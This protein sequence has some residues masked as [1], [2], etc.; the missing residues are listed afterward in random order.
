[1]NHLKYVGRQNKYKPIVDKTRSLLSNNSE[2]SKKAADFL[3]QGA[4][5]YIQ[6]LFKLQKNRKVSSSHIEEILADL[7]RMR[8]VNELNIQ[9]YVTRVFSRLLF[10]Q[11]RIKQP[12][13]EVGCGDGE[14][15]RIA[16][17]EKILVGTDLHFNKNNIIHFSCKQSHAYLVCSDIEKLPFPSKHFKTVLCI[18]TIYHAKN[19]VRALKELSRVT[20]DLLLFDDMSDHL[21]IN[22]PFQ[23]LF[24]QFGLY[25]ASKEMSKAVSKAYKKIIYKKVL[26]DFEI[27]ETPFM[28][29]PLAN[30]SYFLYDLNTIFQIDATQ[31]SQERRESTLEFL[32]SVVAPLIR[33]DREICKAKGSAYKLIIAKRKKST[34]KVSPIPFNE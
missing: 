31:S 30:I 12:S 32:K 1:M 5:F 2:D 16:F 11:K 15:S 7:H 33:K 24:R 14:T 26:K 27:K 10:G 34:E 4:L 6:N 18:N 25:K 22:R 19:K 21:V 13:L 17:S 28:S 3:F 8:S 23:S 9:Y 29:V 20:S